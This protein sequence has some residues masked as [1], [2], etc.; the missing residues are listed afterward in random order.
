MDIVIG[1]AIKPEEIAG[2]KN[3]TELTKV[4]R[5]RTFSL[6]RQLPEPRT[7]YPQADREFV[8]RIKTG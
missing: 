7:G 4:L 6:A 2:Y 5:D 8:F 1:D 3:R